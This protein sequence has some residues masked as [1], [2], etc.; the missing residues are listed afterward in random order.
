MA[1]LTAQTLVPIGAVITAVVMTVGVMRVYS[2][3]TAQTATLKVQVDALEQRVARNEARLDK[4]DERWDAIKE[5]LAKIK[6]RLGIVEA[7][8]LPK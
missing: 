3:D 5:D 6:E 1:K 2:A 4:S 7:R 8:P